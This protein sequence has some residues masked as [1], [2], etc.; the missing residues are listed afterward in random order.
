MNDEGVEQKIPFPL[1]KM[2]LDDF[3]L[4]VLLSMIGFWILFLSIP[5]FIVIA[6]ATTRNAEEDDSLFPLY[7]LTTMIKASMIFMVAL[8]LHQLIWFPEERN[9]D[10]QLLRIQSNEKQEFQNSSNNKEATLS[11]SVQQPSTYR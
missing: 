7:T 9:K 8:K 11:S 6:T 1:K 5:F 10:P 3:G 4:R 2:K